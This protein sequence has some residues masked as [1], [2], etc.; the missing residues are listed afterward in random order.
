MV[1]VQLEHGLP[2]GRHVGRDRVAGRALRKE[3]TAPPTPGRL[4]E[5]RSSAY[6]R[7]STC[8]QHAVVPEDERDALR[9]LYETW[10]TDALVTAATERRDEYAPEAVQLIENEIRKRELRGTGADSPQ[11]EVDTPPVGE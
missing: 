10:S 8:V 2:W 4:S 1:A 11:P 5:I 3:A 6:A 9:R 7:A